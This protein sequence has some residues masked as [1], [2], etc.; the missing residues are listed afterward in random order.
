MS[1]AAADLE[2]SLT[3]YVQ[4]SPIRSFWIPPPAALAT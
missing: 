4:K 2:D 1:A 3:S